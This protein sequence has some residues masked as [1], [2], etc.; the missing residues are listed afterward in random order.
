MAIF[1]NGAALIYDKDANALAVQNGVAI[2]VDTPAL[3]AAVRDPTGNISRYML[4]DTSGRPEMKLGSWFGS[5]APTVGLKTLVD[6]IPVALASDQP[7]VSVTTGSG[8]GVIVVKTPWP[9]NPQRV[10]QDLVRSAG[11]GALNVNGSVT[12]VVFTYAADPSKNILIYDVRFTMVDNTV[13]FG[14]NKFAAGPALPNG[15][16]LETFLGGV[17][18]SI[19]NMK[20]NEHFTQMLP[21][22][23]FTW[24]QNGANDIIVSGLSFGGAIVLA[25][26]SADTIRVTI[27]DN[28]AAVNFFECKVFGVKDL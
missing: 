15:V 4:G 17:P 28:L 9:S 25:A 21:S 10:K 8:V 24:D 19:H 13:P 1:P 27:R 20:I 3:L 5:A 7:P 14:D 11:S 26:G 22:E 23:P 12:P 16:L 2:P 18:T 6:S